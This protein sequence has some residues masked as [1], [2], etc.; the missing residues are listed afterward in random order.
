MKS[1]VAI[2]TKAKRLIDLYKGYNRMVRVGFSKD[3]TK[4]LMDKFGLSLGNVVLD[5][6]YMLLAGGLTRYSDSFSNSTKERATLLK[7]DGLV[8]N[9]ELP[10]WQNYRSFYALEMIVKRLEGQGSTAFSKPDVNQELSEVIGIDYT[11]AGDLL[12]STLSG[13]SYKTINAG[14]DGYF[15]TPAKNYSLEEAIAD[16]LIERLRYKDIKVSSRDLIFE[17]YYTDEQRQSI[18]LSIEKAL[19]VVTGGAGTG[20]TTV[21]KGVI[22]N[23]KKVFGRDSEVI[24]CAP[25]GKA[26]QRMSEATSLSATTI[27]SLLK[28]NPEKGF[29]EAN[30]PANASAIIIDE[31]S[32]I[33][34]ALILKLLESVPEKTK[35]VFVGDI[36]QILPVKPGQPFK[37]MILSD[38]LPTVRLSVPQRTGAKSYIYLNA[39]KIINGVMPTLDNSKMEDFHFT[40]THSDADTA[41]EIQRILAEDIEAVY[42]SSLSNVQIIS[43]KREPKGY[44]GMTGLNRSVQSLLNSEAPPYNKD[45]PTA[46]KIYVGDKVVFYRY[47]Y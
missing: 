2:G 14:S 35:V 38:F 16:K 6:P 21:I 28:F 32:M 25:T 26:A 11:E 10:K 7:V 45:N 37:D 3:E 42:G 20:K 46:Q 12:N 4:F 47:D 1:A 17:D 39:N 23:I 41:K 9:P 36:Q 15:I 30:V 18:K 40:K 19:L 29:M 31:A 13:N 33:D 24:L 8:D 34:S 27:H 44:V 5:N 43:P 22:Q